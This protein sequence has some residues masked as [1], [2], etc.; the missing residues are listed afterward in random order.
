MQ[1]EAI[2]AQHF[3]H[4]IANKSTGANSRGP[5]KGRISTA[6]WGGQAPCEGSVLQTGVHYCLT[7]ISLLFYEKLDIC[8]GDIPINF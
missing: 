7:F 2:K 3:G 4:V 1:T 6:L 5:E 8:Y